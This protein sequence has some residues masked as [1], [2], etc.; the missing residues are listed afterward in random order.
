ME[1]INYLYLAHSKLRQCS[2]GPEILL[3]ELPPA[4]NGISKVTRNNNVIWE[5][6]FLT[7]EENMSHNIANLE[8]HHFKYNLFRQ[9]GDVHVHFFGTSVLSFLDNITNRKWGCI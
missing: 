5:K 6:Q 1:K 3:G 4:V 2:Y 7:G 8:H 9:P